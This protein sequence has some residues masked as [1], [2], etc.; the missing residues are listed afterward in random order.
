MA[1][2]ILPVVYVLDEFIAVDRYCDA[3]HVDLWVGKRQSGLSVSG[4]AIDPVWR[5]P[6]AFAK[7]P[8][9]AETPAAH[10]LAFCSFPQYRAEMVAILQY[11]IKTSGDPDQGSGSPF[12][13]LIINMEIA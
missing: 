13:G 7:D 9:D 8:P 6:E 12:F 5:N 10:A 3:W 11:Q 1:V 2:E 4:V